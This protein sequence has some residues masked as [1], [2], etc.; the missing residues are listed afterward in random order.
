MS[1]EAD[2]RVSANTPTPPGTGALS[3]LPAPPDMTPPVD[4]D[5]SSNAPVS[6]TGTTIT[7]AG[8][9]DCTSVA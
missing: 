6:P 8:G 4:T 1:T 9:G 3:D 5:T 7:L 2:P